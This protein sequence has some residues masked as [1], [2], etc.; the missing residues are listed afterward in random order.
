M[1]E[2]TNNVKIFAIVKKGDYD[3]SDVIDW[4]TSGDWLADCIV[5]PKSETIVCVREYD[6]EKIQKASHT[7]SNGVRVYNAT[8]ADLIFEDS[9]GTVIII[10]PAYEIP[11]CPV[12]DFHPVPGIG[13]GKFKA[14]YKELIPQNLDGI[15]IIAAV[16]KLLGY[17]TII[18]GDGDT[19]DT[20]Q[21]V[22]SGIA[23]SAKNY[24]FR[25]DKFN[26]GA[27]Y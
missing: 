8:G 13:Q 1:S 2:S 23:I 7:F 11:D 27:K 25:C 24:H 17:D 16:Q 3:Y 12:W 15:W 19:P 10:P 21:Q 26:I 14:V 6:A 22:Y 9:D 4:N 18:I 5:S 20:Y